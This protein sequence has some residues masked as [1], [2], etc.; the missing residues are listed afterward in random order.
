MSEAGRKTWNN[1]KT[2]IPM[3][4]GVL[5]LVNLLNPLLNN[6]YPKVF[7]NNYFLDPFLGAIGGSISFGIPLTSYVA[8]GELLSQGVSLLAVTAFLLAWTTVGLAM[9]P[10]EIMY[11]GKKFAI[12]R[13]IINF[14]F[15]I[16]I[17]VLTIITLSVLNI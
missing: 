14:F 17:A 16:I 4:I 9:L 3:V 1:I 13:N 11:L 6:F 8:G 7:T 5:L 2:S 10:L 12:W 15:S